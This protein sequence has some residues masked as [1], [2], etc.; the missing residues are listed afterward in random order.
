MLAQLFDRSD[1]HQR[2]TTLE[3]LLSAAGRDCRVTREQAERIAPDEVER[4][5]LEAER[6]NPSVVEQVSEFYAGHPAVVKNLGATALTIAIS[7]IA[8]ALS[9]NDRI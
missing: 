4:L 5:A 6:N 3:R 8:Q 7:R 2:A 9:W 1:G